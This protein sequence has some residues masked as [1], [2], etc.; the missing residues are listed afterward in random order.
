VQS[1]NYTTL[2]SSHLFWESIEL[3]IDYFQPLTKLGFELPLYQS[4]VESFSVWYGWIEDFK[5][6]H[7]VFF[8]GTKSE[9]ILEL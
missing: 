8:C 6:Y 5:S 7:D 9:K 3:E 2:Y 4:F 1:L